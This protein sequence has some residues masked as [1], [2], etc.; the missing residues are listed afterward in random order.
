MT[1]KIL[2]VTDAEY[3]RDPCSVPS[4]S[5]SIAHT[6]VTQSPLHAWAEHPRLGNLP[7]KSTDAT[8]DGNLLHALLLG[9][10]ME[11][12]DIIDHDDYRTNK[13]KEARDNAIAQGLI[14]IKRKD[15]D[16]IQGAL[17]QIQA[18]IA[19]TGISLEGEREAAFEWEEKGANGPVVCRGRMDIVR[20]QDGVIIDIKK[21]RDANPDKLRRHFT[22]YGYH[23][24]HAAYTSA[25]EKYSAYEGRSDLV[26]RIKF[27]FLFVELD[28]PYAVCLPTLSGA[29][30][31]LGE[32]HWEKAV[33]VW[34]RCLAANEWP[35]YVD[36]A[37]LEPMPWLMSE[38]IGDGA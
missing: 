30:R 17:T 23:I 24:Q 4:L 35:G 20:A 27:Q 19:A 11:K 21:T 7:R 33:R 2:T 12:I 32:R 26:G 1:S 29:M 36:T 25:L 18:N 28:P 9:K 13:A 10:G 31:E 3:H 16:G 22:D 14:P 6:L 15:F 38:S 5:Q 37:P 8:D 34:E